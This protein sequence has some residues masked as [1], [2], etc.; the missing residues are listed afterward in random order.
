MQRLSTTVHKSRRFKALSTTLSHSRGA[1]VMTSSKPTQKKT[2]TKPSKESNIKIEKT[3][4][5]MRLRSVKESTKKLNKE[6]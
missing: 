2:L 5:E 1:I 3:S 6:R 4:G